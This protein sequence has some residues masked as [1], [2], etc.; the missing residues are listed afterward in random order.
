MQQIEMV[1]RI[2]CHHVWNRNASQL[3]EPGLLSVER[4]RG[5]CVPTDESRNEDRLAVIQLC[6]NTAN[7][8]VRRIGFDDEAATQAAQR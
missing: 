1:Y 8:D 4:G 6:I 2:G 5:R 7:L 3:D